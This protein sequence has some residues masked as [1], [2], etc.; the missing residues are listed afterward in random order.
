MTFEVK[1][2]ERSASWLPTGSGLAVARA[3]PRVFGLLVLA[4]LLVQGTL[5]QGH[6]HLSGRTSPAAVASVEQSLNGAKP[7]KGDPLTGC[8]LCHEAAIAG[9]YLLPQATAIPA[10]PTAILWLFASPMA[11]FGLP[12][13][14][15]GW[16]S[17]APPQ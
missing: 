16:L 3:W 1:S 7:A 4:C 6:V 14:A 2:G 5:V 9:A 13:P 10:P 15:S 12:S 17:R 11:A 8:V